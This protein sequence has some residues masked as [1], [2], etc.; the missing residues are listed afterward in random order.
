MGAIPAPIRQCFAQRH[1]VNATSQGRMTGEQSGTPGRDDAR[2]SADGIALY[3]LLTLSPSLLFARVARKVGSH[4]SSCPV[5]TT[6][7]A[8]FAAQAANDPY[9]CETHVLF[10]GGVS[11]LAVGQLG[12]VQEGF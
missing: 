6:L 9:A 11:P 7:P 3:S 8:P 12:Q 4:T 2:F 5:Q 10:A 1:F